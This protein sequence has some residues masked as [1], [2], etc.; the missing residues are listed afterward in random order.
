MAKAPRKWTITPNRKAIVIAM[1]EKQ[2]TI[3]TL[4]TSFGLTEKTMSKALKR[5]GIEPAKYRQSGIAN[6]RSRMF[7]R[8]ET[9]DKDKDYVEL[10]MKLVDKYEVNDEAV[11][12]T[13]S[14]KKLNTSIQL[15]ILAEL[16]DD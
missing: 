3:S 13:G 1:L 7:E 9:V 5:A 4:A 6:I 11:V 15:K 14:N 8:L 10:A 12:S 2:H 16:A